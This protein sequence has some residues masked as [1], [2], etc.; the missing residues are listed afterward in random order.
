MVGWITTGEAAVL[1][2]VSRQKVD[3]DRQLGY[4]RSKKVGRDVF[5]WK[6]DVIAFSKKGLAVPYHVRYRPGSIPGWVRTGQAAKMLRV[7]RR[8]VNAHIKCGNLSGVK[9]GRDTF[10]KRADVIAF[11]KDRRNPGWQH[12]SRKAS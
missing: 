7:T 5:Y 3:K 4:L 9:L 11:K 10:L 2:G 12:P 8:M 1:L 6:P